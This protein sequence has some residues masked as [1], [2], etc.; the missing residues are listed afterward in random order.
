M[1]IFKE[2]Q[3]KSVHVYERVLFVE[4]K[5]IHFLIFSISITWQI[6]LLVKIFGC[7][8]VVCLH[9]YVNV[10]K[11][12]FMYMC[13]CMYTYVC[14]YMCKALNFDW[15]VARFLC[16]LSLACCWDLWKQEQ[17]LSRASTVRECITPFRRTGQST[18]ASPPPVTST[19]LVKSRAAV[20]EVVCNCAALLL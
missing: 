10:K 6:N 4:R 13:I 1:E 11:C 20:L 5:T 3:K 14:I 7:G 17:I 8:L 18:W 15:D 12:I 19:R 16:S 9:V 2:W